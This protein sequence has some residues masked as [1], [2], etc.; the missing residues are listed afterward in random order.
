MLGVGIEVQPLCVGW[1]YA[2]FD[3]ILIVH[4]LPIL[5]IFYLFK[6]YIDNTYFIYEVS[7]IYNAYNIFVQMCT[8]ILLENK[9]V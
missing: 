7:V 5:A 6:L 1:E 9:D 4:L 3:K 2:W 8:N